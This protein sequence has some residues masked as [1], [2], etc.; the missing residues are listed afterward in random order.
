MS[1]RIS[2][3]LKSWSRSLSAKWHHRKPVQRDLPGNLSLEQAG[4]LLQLQQHPGWPHFLS[5]LQ[6]WSSQI[7]S[8]VLSGKKSL[9]EYHY[10]TGKL[11]AFDQMAMLP[12]TLSL[13][14]RERKKVDERRTTGPDRTT[15]RLAY[16]NPYYRGHAYGTSEGADERPKDLGAR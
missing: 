3:T 9:D 16:G 1:S 5:V 11:Q 13:A 4:N 2:M 8:E 10:L 15:D 14:I 6:T 7:A 12:D